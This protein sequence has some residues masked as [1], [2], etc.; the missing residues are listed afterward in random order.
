MFGVN[1][2]VYYRKIERK[3]S[4]Q[5]KDTDVISMVLDIRKLML[6]LGIKKTYH[7]LLG[8]LQLMKIGTDKL[9]K[10]LRANHLLIQPKRFYNITTN[11]HYRF[12]KHQNHIL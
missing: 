11:S 1:R 10:I 9:F 7:V 4:K 3:V 12:K 5:A 2:Q 8:E 6:R